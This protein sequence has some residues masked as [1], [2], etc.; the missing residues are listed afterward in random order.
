MEFRKRIEESY[1]NTRRPDAERPMVKVDGSKEGDNTVTYDKGGWVF[2]MLNDL[3][4]RERAA[5]RPPR[6]RDHASRT[7]P[8]SR[9]CRTSSRSC[10]RHAADPDAFDAF[11]EQWFYQVVVPEYRFT[12]LEKTR[13]G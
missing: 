6:V 4:G 9:C 2:W 5:R 13:V 3:M 8:T 11:V 10:A 12:E 1:A 7:G